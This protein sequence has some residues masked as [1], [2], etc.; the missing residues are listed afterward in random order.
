MKRIK[1]DPYGFAAI[2]LMMTLMVLALYA[3]LWLVI[4]VAIPQRLAESAE[5]AKQVP[6]HIRLMGR[7]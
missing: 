1:D 2:V 7:E 6:E 5:A 3:L 4:D